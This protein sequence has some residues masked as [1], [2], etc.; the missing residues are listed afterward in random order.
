[1]QTL[2]RLCV[3]SSPKVI[4]DITGCNNKRRC[5]IG[6]IGHSSEG[7]RASG[8]NTHYRMTQSY[9]QKPTNRVEI[10]LSLAQRDVYDTNL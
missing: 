7:S 5:C 8:D 9:T 4:H 6:L 10:K 1:M 3:V 2:R